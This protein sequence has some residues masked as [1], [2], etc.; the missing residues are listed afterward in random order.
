MMQ[1]NED[2]VTI[3]RP[4]GIHFVLSVDDRVFVHLLMKG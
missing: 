4:L 3:D 2:V 1:V